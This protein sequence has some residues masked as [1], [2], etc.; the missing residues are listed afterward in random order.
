[1][2]FP[3]DMTTG[4][5]WERADVT[6]QWRQESSQQAGGT[7]IGKDLG[8]PIWKADFETMPLEK[9]EAEALHAD[10]LTLGGLART[11]FAHTAKRPEPVAMKGAL[12]SGVTIAEIAADRSSM[13]LQGLADAQRIT[14]G[15]FVSIT[16]STGGRELVKAA[17]TVEVGDNG[18][19]DWFAI[20]PYLRA[21]VALGDAVSLTP[22]QIELRLE[23]DGL[24]EPQ[25]KSGNLYTVKFKASQVIR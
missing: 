15:D 13:R 25:R 17:Q 16:V 7:T 6:L 2:I 19:S 21:V 1:M 22:P 14:G 4:Q 23:K 5:D 3:R 10:F 9:E 12:L 18:Q 11:F 8:S 20:A 24:Q